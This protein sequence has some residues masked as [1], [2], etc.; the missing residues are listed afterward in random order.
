MALLSRVADRIYWGARY[1]ERA[2]DTARIIRAFSDLLIDLPT[3]LLRGG[4]RRLARPKDVTP[5]AD[6]VQLGGAA[7]DELPRLCAFLRER[8]W[9][10]PIFVRDDR[11]D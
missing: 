8:S 2:E 7:V 11:W 10:G 3:E 9:C 6:G 4:I 1:A 5:V